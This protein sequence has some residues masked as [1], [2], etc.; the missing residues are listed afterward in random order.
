MRRSLRF[1]LPILLLG[2]FVNNSYGQQS[3][4]KFERYSLEQGLSQS[5]IYAIIQ[6]RQGF[7]WFA[8]EDG[9]NRFDGYNFV[10][11]KYKPQD[12]NSLSSSVITGLLQD[13]D[14]IIWITTTH[15]LNSYD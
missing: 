10:V 3:E 12:R 6:D 7:L 1:I 8:T 9:L 4:A 13:R 5:A 2:I 14:G 11:Y 15:G